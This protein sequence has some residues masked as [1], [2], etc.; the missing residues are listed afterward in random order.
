ML[1]KR[2]RLNH[3]PASNKL[4]IRARV[5]RQRPVSRPRLLFPRLLETGEPESPLLIERAG[6]GRPGRC[7]S[8]CPNFLGSDMM[9]CAIAPPRLAR[10]R[11]GFA[12][13]RGGHYERIGCR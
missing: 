4:E 8:P 5:C 7:L 11:G 1:S 2:P 13:A 6:V 10:V 9:S 3:P 12:V